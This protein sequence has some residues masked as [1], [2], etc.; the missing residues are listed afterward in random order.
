MRLKM[1]VFLFSCLLLPGPVLAEVMSV[2][3]SGAEMRSAPSSMNS[4]VLSELQLYAPLEVLEK[5]AEYYKVKDYRDRAGWVHRS[6]LKPASGLVVT[7]DRANVRQ[8]PGA[9]HPVIFQLAKGDTCRL[10]SK[11]GKWLEI[12]TPTGNTGW[13]AE[14]LT[15]GQ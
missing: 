5:G 6:L 10:I 12:Q 9:N 2:S 3:Y 8:G 11:E 1:F 13:I 4:K 7:G 15:W 14:F